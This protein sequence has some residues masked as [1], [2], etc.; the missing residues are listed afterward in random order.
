MGSP[1][2]DVE[3][4]ATGWRPQVRRT[5]GVRTPSAARRQ[6][7]PRQATT[8][9]NERERGVPRTSEAVAQSRRRPSK[10]RSMRVRHTLSTHE[11]SECCAGCAGPSGRLSCEACGFLQ[12]GHLCE[13]KPGGRSI[14]EREHEPGPPQGAGGPG[15]GVF[16]C[17]RATSPRRPCLTRRQATG[18]RAGLLRPW[19]RVEP[20]SRVLAWREGM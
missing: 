19:T 2:R 18:V 4:S 6:P 5:H 15:H 17:Q 16:P 14:S 12:R 13:G 9:R 20:R 8:G 10:E 3:T 7:K 1:A 11:H